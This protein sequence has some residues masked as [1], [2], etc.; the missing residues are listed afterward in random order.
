MRTAVLLPATFEKE[1]QSLTMILR[2]WKIKCDE[3]SHQYVLKNKEYYYFW[4]E[5]IEQMMENLKSDKTSIHC[6]LKFSGNDT[7]EAIAFCGESISKFNNE[8]GKKESQFH[9]FDYLSAPW[10]VADELFT[11]D[12]IISKDSYADIEYQLI[13]FILLHCKTLKYSE[14]FY[15]PDPKLNKNVISK[16][17]NQLQFDSSYRELFRGMYVN[18][19]KISRETLQKTYPSNQFNMGITFFDGARNVKLIDHYSDANA[20]PLDQII[21]NYKFQ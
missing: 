10:N 15:E 21:L 14:I 5:T 20:T 8:H 9:I 18:G 6:F 1:K 12:N 4:I 11:S 19:Y 16:L 7:L 2:S 3:Y 17:F 13:K